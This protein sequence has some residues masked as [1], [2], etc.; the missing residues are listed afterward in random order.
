MIAS[1][2][3]RKSTDQEK[4]ASGASESV[5]RQ[6]EHAKAF[7]ARKGWALGPVYYDDNVSGAAYAKLVERNRMADD[8]EAGKFQIL[9][10]SEQSRLGR[11]MIEVAYTIKR[12]AEGGVRIF[13]YLDDAEISVEDEVAQAMTF[14]RSFSSASERRQTSK[15][16]FDAAQRRVRAGAVAGAK[17]YGYDHQRGADGLVRR[18]INPA[19]AAVLVRIFTAYAEGIGSSTL[20]RR[21]NAEGVP[22]PRAKGWAQGGIKGMI[23]NPLYRGLVVWGKTQGIVRKGHRT[24]RPRVVGDWE[25][26]E[27]PHLR[28]IPEDLWTRVQAQRQRRRRSFPRSPRSGR[29]LGRPGW[30]DGD[31]AFLLTGFGR[32][33]TCGDGSIRVTHRRHGTAAKRVIVRS[34]VCSIHDTRGPAKCSNNTLVRVGALDQALIDALAGI[35]DDHRLLEA[36]VDRALA[37]LLAGQQH[38]LDRRAVLERE[39]A[40]VQHRLDRALDTFLDGQGGMPEIR[41]KIEADRERKDA[42]TAALSAL[43]AAPPAL[44]PEPIKRALRALAT[45]LRALLSSNIQQARAVL[46]RL[47][48]GRLIDIEPFH[49]DGRKGFRF[50]GVVAFHRLL[51]GEA[52]ASLSGALRCA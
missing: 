21:L 37:R 15:R 6:L 8:A 42:L 32:C 49:A 1:S 47:L 35:L 31:S 29:L 44:E 16:V 48:D 18:V 13:A 7:I 41:A 46:R 25:R 30:H 34:Y 45:D 39:L 19:Q 12:I 27:A 22:A 3:G 51:S 20:A 11:D 5:E 28:I 26:A 50:H 33:T 24:T 40:Q 43:A 23:V 52:L 38:G 36:A 17:V 2:Y 4:G 9:V 14:L 10:V